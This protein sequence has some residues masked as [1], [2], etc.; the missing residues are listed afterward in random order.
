MEGKRKKLKGCG[1]ICQHS[2]HS[3]LTQQFISEFSQLN[4]CNFFL[5][6]RDSLH[7]ADARRRSLKSALTIWALIWSS[8][9]V[10]QIHSFVNVFFLAR[11]EPVE[12][13]KLVV[14]GRWWCTFSITVQRG[15]SFGLSKGYLHIHTVCELMARLE[16]K[17]FFV[18]GAAEWSVLFSMSLVCLISLHPNCNMG[19]TDPRSAPNSNF[20]H[21]N[22]TTES[23]ALARRQNSHL[24]THLIYYL[25]LVILIFFGVILL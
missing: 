18:W 7:R 24:L 15:G 21:C 13:N 12:G 25:L 14:S 10:P 5:Y 4:K 9:Q 17:L 1:E 8:R 20:S 16:M 22:C 6:I 23:C 2:A 3:L 11:T 19:K